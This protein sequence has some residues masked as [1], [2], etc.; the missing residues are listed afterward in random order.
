MCYYSNVQFQSQRV[1]VVAALN[2]IKKI[3]ISGNAE[4]DTGIIC[5]SS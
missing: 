5:H 2:L 3:K 4:D 1:K